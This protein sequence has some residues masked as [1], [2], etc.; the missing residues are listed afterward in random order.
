MKNTTEKHS[1]TTI[2]DPKT[3][4]TAGVS[5]QEEQEA[6]AAALI[7]R[8]RRNK[9]IPLSLG[10]ASLRI[11][12]EA[13]Y[14]LISPETLSDRTVWLRKYDQIY[15]KVSTVQCVV[16]SMSYVICISCYF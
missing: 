1:S 10:K 8:N 9:Q 11:R 15:E 4:T 14:S 2:M 6:D 5:V 16:C 3:K 13:Y 12:L 7:V